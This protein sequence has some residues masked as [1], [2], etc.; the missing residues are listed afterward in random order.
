MF[1]KTVKDLDSYVEKL[2]DSIPN[3]IVQAQYPTMDQIFVLMEL[4]RK[5][6][7]YDAYDLLDKTFFRK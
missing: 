4:A 6:K 7:M 1:I 2:I 5:L 3:E